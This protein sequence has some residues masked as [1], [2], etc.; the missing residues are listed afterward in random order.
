MISKDNGDRKPPFL[1]RWI[2]F[3]TF[4]YI[5]FYLLTKSKDMILLKG[6]IEPYYGLWLVI[7]IK[8]L[9]KD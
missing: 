3:V 6:I 8:T 7:F 2:K 1:A 4:Y 5:F 9:Q